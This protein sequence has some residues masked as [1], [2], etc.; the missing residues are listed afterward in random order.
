[1]SLRDVLPFTLKLPEAIASAKTQTELEEVA[2]LGAGSP[3]G[4]SHGSIV[5]I[6]VFQLCCCCC[7]TVFVVFSKPLQSGSLSVP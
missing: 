5:I 6:C 3:L 4:P 1:M 2:Q 7:Y